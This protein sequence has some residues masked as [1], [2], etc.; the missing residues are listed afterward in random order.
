M[1]VDAF[2]RQ[3]GGS[4]DYSS[5]GGSAFSLEFPLPPGSMRPRA[6]ASSPED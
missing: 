5:R 1:I 4:L 6:R 2:A 3:L